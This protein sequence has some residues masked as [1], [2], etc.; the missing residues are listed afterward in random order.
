MITKNNIQM[1]E[2]IGLEVE[3]IES[4][5]APYKGIKGKVIN[6]QKNVLIIE[7]NIK[8]KIIPKK[9]NVFQFKVG[10]ESIKVKGDEICYA[11]EDRLKKVKK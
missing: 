1:H 9:G 7:D 8:E 3:I 4:V 6:E 5:S 2:L 11:P 10:K